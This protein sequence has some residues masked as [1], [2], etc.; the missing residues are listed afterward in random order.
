MWQD[1][2]EQICFKLG[3][4]LSTNL[5]SLTPILMTL[6][7]T[8]GHRVTDKLELVLSFF[9]ML[10]EATQMFI[11]VGYIEKMAMKKSYKYGKCGSFEHSL[12][13]ACF[14]VFVSEV[15]CVC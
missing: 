2:S 9:S 7:F 15:A 3:M 12:L 4:M 11:M 1:I 8:Q 10:Y 6:I 13:F 14:F 5:Y